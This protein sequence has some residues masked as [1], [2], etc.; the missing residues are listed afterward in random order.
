MSTPEI[1]AKRF[2][3]DEWERLTARERRV[4]DAILN[5]AM[6]S[7]DTAHEFAV[8]RSL[9]ERLA[10]RIATFGGSWTFILLFLATMFAWAMLNTEIL[11]PRSRAFD[12]YPYIFLNLMLSM[13]AAL[14]A[15]LILMSQNR[16]STLDRRQAS[17]D[18]EVNLKAEVEIRHLHDKLDSLRET[19][20]AELVKQQEREIEMLT[21]IIGARDGSAT[22]GPRATAD[23]DAPPP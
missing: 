15:P 2:L 22:P 6:I 19:Q 18:F 7:R 1:L 16:Q 5:R 12:P 23:T 4:I 14:Q 13:L 11:G 10:D 3:R 20:W 9:G 17:A 8:D 21:Q